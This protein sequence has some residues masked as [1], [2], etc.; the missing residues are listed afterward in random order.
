MPCAVFK[1][2]FAP[3]PVVAHTVG[4]DEHEDAANAF[5]RILAVEDGVISRRTNHT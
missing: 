3:V 1:F 2:Q 4:A 5:D